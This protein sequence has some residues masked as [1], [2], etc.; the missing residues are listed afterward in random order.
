M[1]R[2]SIASTIAAAVLGALAAPAWAQD[3]TGESSIVVTGKQ[4]LTEKQ[5]LEVVRRAAQPVDGQLARFRHPVC[6]RVTG[7]K[8]EYEAIVAERIKEMARAV[9]AD[10]GGE[11]CVTNF[12]VVIVDDGGEFMEELRREHP[13]ALA[14]L[15]ERQFES[16]AAS[17]ST[18]LSWS[19][20]V[21][22]NSAGAV[23]GVPSSTFGGGNV[24]WGYQGADLS[25]GAKTMR[26]Y[27]GSNVN[28]GVEQAIASAWVVLE[29]RATI[30]KTL[31]QIA[32]YAAMRGLAMINPSELTGSADTI[33]AL[34]EPDVE[35]APAGMTEFD[36]AYLTGLYQIQGRRWARQQVRQLASTIAESARE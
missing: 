30:G 22:T 33:L 15:S 21:M 5:T 7:Y 18:A 20:T 2:I 31:N 4:P 3:E 36:L 23:V 28:P 17:G 11:G 13:E 27:E 8:Q 1:S 32:D 12:Y 9:G 25:L 14:G 6:P 16:L 24:K 29:T 35:Q 10:A 26:V 34:F 19:S